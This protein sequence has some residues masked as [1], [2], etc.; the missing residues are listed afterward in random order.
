MGAALLMVVAGCTAD[1]QDPKTAAPG[2]S[3]GAVPGFADGEIPPVPL[4]TL[5]DLSLLHAYDD[6]FTVR[7][8]DIANTYPG[9]TV[10]PAAC[11]DSGSRITSDGAILAYGD[12]STSYTGADGTTVLNFGDGSGSYHGADGTEIVNNGNGSGTYHGA[13]GTQVVNDG[14]GTGSYTSPDGTEMK[15][16]GDGAGW[17]HAPDGSETT[18]YGNG[19]GTY[20]GADGSEIVNKGDGTGSYRGSDGGTIVNDGAGTAT[21]TDSSGT[22]R[23]VDADPLPTVPPLGNFPPIEALTPQA[24]C[25]V[26]ITVD[27][28]LLFDFGDDRLRPEAQVVLATVAQVLQDNDVPAATVEGHTDSLGGDN[29]NQTLSKSRA[30]AVAN[31]LRSAGVTCDLDVTGYGSSRPVALNTNPDGTDNPAGRQLNRRVEIFIRTF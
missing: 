17:Y 24:A 13:D 27:A 18:N 8:A 23:K 19:A 30:D 14:G 31:A 5:P 29:L 21:V 4:F 12:G 10:A 3:A 26:A 25:G 28:G 15:I 20:Q 2:S 6:A 9:L 1:T 7:F 11:D 16:Y 22:T